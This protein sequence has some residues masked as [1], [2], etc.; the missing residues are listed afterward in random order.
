MWRKN[1]TGTGNQRSVGTVFPGIESGTG[2]AG[3]V[4]REP[5]WEPYLS[6]KLYRKTESPFSQVPKRVVSKRVV[7]A[8][9]PLYRHFIFLTFW[10][11]YVLA[12][13][14]CLPPQ[15]GETQTKSASTLKGAKGASVKMRTFSNEGNQDFFCHC[16]PLLALAS[17][18]KTRAY[19]EQWRQKNLMPSYY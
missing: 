4:F 11:F 13:R 17:T 1:R 12:V 19:P 5:K 3:T 6:V 16:W 18:K 8:D 10:F 7:L 15:R 9:V 2:T 14:R